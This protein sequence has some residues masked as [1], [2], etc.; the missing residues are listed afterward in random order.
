MQI[1]RSYDVLVSIINTPYNQIPTFQQNIRAW[2]INIGFTEAEVREFERVWFTARTFV[3]DQQEKY[4][5]T[6]DTRSDQMYILGS[7]GYSEKEARKIS[8]ALFQC[9]KCTSAVLQKYYG[10]NALQA[11]RIEYMFKI[12]TGKISIETNDQLIKHF[13]TMTNNAHKLTV[14]DLAVS[15]VT[16]VPRFAV[17]QNIDIEPYTIWN[18][19]NYKGVQRLYKVYET[20]GQSVTVETKRSPR[21]DYGAS[22]EIPGVLKIHGKTFDGN[23]RVTFDKKYCRLVNRFI[24]IASLKNPEK[25]CGKYDI[26]TSDGNRVYVYATNMGTKETP[27]YQMSNQRVY[28]YGIF[29]KQIPSKLKSVAEEMYRYTGGYSYKLCKPTVE[30]HTLDRVRIVEDMDDGDITV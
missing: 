29:G 3:S 9:S 26:I 7:M 19:E 1:D 21:L 8:N 5:G 11:K 30:Y 22:K 25:H 2:F 18:S 23:V 15:K 17:I 14:A 13:K 27:K 12:Y 28:A 6:S 24:I 10:Y 20:R 16:S 4:H